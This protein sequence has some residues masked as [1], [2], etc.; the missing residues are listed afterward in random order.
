MNLT[1]RN[2]LAL[3]GAAIAISLV[4]VNAAFAA[5][6]LTMADIEAFTGC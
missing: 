2:A 3:G 1:R 6:D 4:P 5:S